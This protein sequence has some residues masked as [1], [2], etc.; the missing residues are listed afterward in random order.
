MVCQR[1]SVGFIY[2]KIFELASEIGGTDSFN[3]QPEGMGTGMP[4]YSSFSNFGGVSDFLDPLNY[5]G[6]GD[7]SMSMTALLDLES[8]TGMNPSFDPLLSNQNLLISDSGSYSSI[9]S[10]KLSSTSPVTVLDGSSKKKAIFKGG[11]QQTPISHPVISM[12]TPLVFAVEGEKPIV[13]T[14][15]VN[16]ELAD[17]PSEP[18]EAFRFAAAHAAAHASRRPVKLSKSHAV[19]LYAQHL[20]GYSI[21]VV[22]RK[23][24]SP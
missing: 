4:G 7:A 13:D 5:M 20:W 17:M 8:L 6:S 24:L 10:R 14:N 21:F 9:S 2:R 3:C 19:V 16:P 1:R 22:C 23:R 15:S 12:V 18:V 11:S